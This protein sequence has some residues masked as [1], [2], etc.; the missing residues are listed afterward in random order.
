MDKRYVPTWSPTFTTKII[1]ARGTE[2]TIFLH[3]L[4]NRGIVKHEDIF[5]LHLIIKTSGDHQG[6][7]Q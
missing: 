4:V 6:L 5:C 1:A 3:S 2:K 7:M